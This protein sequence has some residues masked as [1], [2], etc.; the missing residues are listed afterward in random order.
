MDREELEERL[1]RAEDALRRIERLKD[2]W[3]APLSHPVGDMADPAYAGAAA[4]AA[5][6]SQSHKIAEN[7]LGKHKDSKDSPRPLDNA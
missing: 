1:F 3:S 4:W 2:R 6:G 5:V 7:V